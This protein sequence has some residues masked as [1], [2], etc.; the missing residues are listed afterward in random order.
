MFQ[1]G[2]HLVVTTDGEDLRLRETASVNGEI[3]RKLQPGIRLSIMEGPLKIDGYTWWKVA[4]DES[5]MEGWV[6]EESSWFGSIP[7]K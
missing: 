1:V 7:E 5:N 3:I 2:S 6:A 4:L